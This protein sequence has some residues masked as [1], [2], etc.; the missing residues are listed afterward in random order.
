MASKP[1]AKAAVKAKPASK[2]TSKKT[3]P[4]T[5][6]ARIRMYRLGVGDCFLVSLPRDGGDFR[7]LID[8]GVHQAQKGGSD[9]IKA[10]IQDLLEVTKG[11]IDVVVGTHEHQDHLSGFPALRDALKAAS[12]NDSIGGIGGIGA[13]WAAWTEDA[14]DDVAKGLRDKKYQALTALTGAGIRMVGAR[15]SD[16]VAKLDSLLGFFGDGSGPRLK[17]F[18]DALKELAPDKIRYH[19]PGEEPIELDGLEARV[20]VLGPPRDKE[21]L[22]RSAPSKADDTEVYKFGARAELIDEIAV[23][24][25]EK[26]AP[27]GSADRSGYRFGAY[28]ELHEQIAPA[29]AEEEPLGP[30]DDR[31]CL[32]L[33][34][35]QTMAFFQKR[36][37]DTVN[38]EKADWRVD[39]TQD[40]RRIDND[41]MSGGTALAI[42][43]N[44]DTNNT[45]L[46]LAIELGPKE[47]N[48][49]VLLFAA[50][51]QVGNWLSWQTLKWT[52]GGRT[53]T[54]NDLL[55]RTI[56][57]KV[58]HHASHNATLNKLGLELM[59]SLDL[60]LVPTDSVMADNVGWGTLPWEPLLKRLK[61][62]AKSGVIRTDQAFGDKTFAN[63]IVKEDP[64]YYE[65]TI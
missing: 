52:W 23:A 44:E 14:N 5:W 42:K 22:G 28:A 62:T 50:D 38:G 12:G 26:S 43:L 39:N 17:K 1:K 53:I 58:G 51:A 31:Y 24:L 9:T 45:S 16:E 59:T 25:R 46:V 33:G 19:T 34:D 60:A 29:F 15:Q 55:K 49:P 11:K 64:L 32:K 20:F 57:Y 18:G 35:T 47:K 2:G 36:Y 27:G 63:A 6:R 48:G 21:L 40:W 3:S 54:A 61:E 4:P 10:V 41:W 37:W 30:F 13:I 8:C 7:M 65:V 56:L